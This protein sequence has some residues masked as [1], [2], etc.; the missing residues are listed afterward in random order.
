MIFA[1]IFL[2]LLPV[3]FEFINHKR[4]ANAPPAPIQE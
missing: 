2:S 4:A 1:V 3:L